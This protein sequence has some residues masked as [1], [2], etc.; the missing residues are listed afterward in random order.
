[1]KIEIDDEIARKCVLSE[2]E[3]LGLLAIAI[4]KAK[5]F[6]THL[7]GKFWGGIFWPMWIGPNNLGE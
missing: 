5:G 1:M 2:R 3:A 4:Y 7:L 6:L